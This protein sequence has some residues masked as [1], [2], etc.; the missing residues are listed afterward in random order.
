MKKQALKLSRNETKK[1]RI[2]IEEAPTFYPSFEE[3]EDPY[4]YIER[5][6]FIIIIIIIFLNYFIF[7]H[8]INIQMHRLLIL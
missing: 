2:K 5:L 6:L 4:V 8:T 1:T 3:F 7:S